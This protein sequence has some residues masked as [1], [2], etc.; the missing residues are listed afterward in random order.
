VAGLDALGEQLLQADRKPE[1]VEV[2][3]QIITM[4]PP[5]A[6]EYR[7]VLAQIGM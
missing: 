7:K 1:A 5:N 2:I 4:N 3:T 6:A